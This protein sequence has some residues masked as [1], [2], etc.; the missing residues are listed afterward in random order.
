MKTF[1]ELNDSGGK[2]VE[3][4][5]R[6]VSVLLGYW[7]M[8]RALIRVLDIAEPEWWVEGVLSLIFRDWGFGVYVVYGLLPSLLAVAAFCIWRPKT[9]LLRWLAAPIGLVALVAV[10]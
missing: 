8:A 6:A 1:S 9:N 10:G 2:K 7:F 5:L 4:G 3:E